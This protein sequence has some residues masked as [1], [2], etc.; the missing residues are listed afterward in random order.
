MNIY[1]IP[2]TTKQN[3]T[4]Y[5]LGVLFGYFWYNQS[6]KWLKLYSCKLKWSQNPIIQSHFSIDSYHK[7]EVCFGRIGNERCAREVRLFLV[8]QWARGSCQTTQGQEPAK[9]LRGQVTEISSARRQCVCHTAT[10]NSHP[11]HHPKYIFCFSATNM[12]R[13]SLFKVKIAGEENLELKIG[14]SNSMN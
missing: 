5:V 9:L 1:C 12:Y 2:L 11:K 13:H 4:P 14:H 6:R 3:K 10:R 8:S 7:K